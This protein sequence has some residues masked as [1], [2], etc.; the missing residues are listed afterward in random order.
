MS[1]YA[2]SDANTSASYTYDAAGQR[3]K[4]EVT[5]SGTQTTTASPC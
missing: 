2:N 3:T 5:V 1:A 4:K